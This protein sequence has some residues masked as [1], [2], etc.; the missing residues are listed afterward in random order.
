MTRI[1]VADDEA[2]IAESTADLLRASGHDVE[3]VGRVPDILPTLLRH[4]A[5]VLLQDVRMPGMD[6]DVHLAAVRSRP[7]LRG[8]RIV[9]F[10]ATVAV[11]G[12][13][14]HRLI[15]AFIAKPF[16]PAELLA[17]VAPS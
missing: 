15:D 11:E 9:L 4:R 2:I 8:L 7:E 16:D 3:I 14:D 10:T 6:L 5:E 17:L 12:L 1:V 13:R